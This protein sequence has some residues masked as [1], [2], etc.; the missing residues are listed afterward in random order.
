MASTPDTNMI[1]LSTVGQTLLPPTITGPIFEK[2]VES[3]AVMQLARKIPLSLTAQTV[4]PVPG[5]IPRAGWTGEGGV[6]PT[7]TASIGTKT[8]RGEKVALMIPVSEEVMRT[9]PAG[10]YE[11]I[12][13]DLPTAIGRAFDYAAI[14]GKDFR[15]G[16]AGPFDSYLAQTPNTVTL[17]TA[18]QNKGG[19][20]ADLAAGRKAVM[21]A[22]GAG[23]DVT[24]FAAD[25]RF[26]VDLQLATDSLG[27]PLWVDSPDATPN[28]GRLL[29]LPA[30]YNAGVS[31]QLYRDSA[32]TDTELRAI[33]G[34]WSQAAYGVGMDLTLKVS[35]QASYV[36]EAGNWHSAYQENLVLLLAEAYF[37]FV[38]A[39]EN[40][41]VKYVEGTPAP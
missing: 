16:G 32:S 23:Y 35:T 34:D 24:G 30:F 29:G 28:S 2:S 8:M 31:G 25:P 19:L 17:G 40:A 18:A 5:D 37:G 9:N 10:I 13:N 4:I 26:Q 11:Q 6:K 27:R 36:D 15:T 41:F 21:N 3:S 33:G 12:Q 14:H 20:Y 1:Q 22:A 39:N 7:G 38:V